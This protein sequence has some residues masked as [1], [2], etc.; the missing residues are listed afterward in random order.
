MHYFAAGAFAAQDHLADAQHEMETLLHED[1]KSPSSTQYRQIL[2]QLHAKQAHLAAAKPHS[3][4]VVN[5]S[6]DQPSKTSH[7]APSKLCKIRKKKFK[8][9]RQKLN[10]IRPVSNAA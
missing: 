7:G 5:S 4:D 1:P 2:D 9:L 6:P 10:R 8:S 3:A